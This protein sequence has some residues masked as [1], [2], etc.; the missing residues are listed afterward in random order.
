MGGA[1]YRQV[2]RVRLIAG[3]MDG[4]NGTGSR[5]V[6]G[7]NAKP[8]DANTWS[9][10]TGGEGLFEPFQNVVDA[11]FGIRRKPARRKRW[12]LRVSSSVGLKSRGLKVRFMPTL[13]KS[14]VRMSFPWPVGEH[15]RKER[16][17]A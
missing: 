6:D 10:Y 12:L 4:G 16:R 7:R 11:V 14:P 17:D 13:L 15:P 3:A 9:R 8:S 2:A 5:P 1:R